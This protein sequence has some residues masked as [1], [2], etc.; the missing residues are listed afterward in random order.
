MSQ[1]PSPQLGGSKGFCKEG[2]ENRA[3]R[4]REEAVKFSTC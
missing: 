2:E 1:S 4:S 3:K